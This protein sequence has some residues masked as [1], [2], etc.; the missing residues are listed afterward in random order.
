MINDHVYWNKSA[1]ELEE[2]VRVAAARQDLPVQRTSTPRPQWR[3]DPYRGQP[4]YHVIRRFVEAWKADNEADMA[5]KH[6]NVGDPFLK[7]LEE[8]GLRGMGGAG[9]PT[10][11]KWSAVR[12]APGKEKYVVCNG[13]ESEPGTFKD[14][15]LLVFTPHLM[16]EG[17]ILAGL[18][19]G[20]TRGYI[21]IRHEYQEQIKA[22]EAEIARAQANHFCGSNIL[23][24]DFS[25]PVEVFVSPGGYICGEETALLEAMEDRRAEP[26]NKPPI[27]VFEG[28]YGKPTIINNV[29]TFSWVPSIVL[30]GGPWYRELG[31]HQARGMR[32][33][34]ISGHVARPGVYEVPLG[35]TVG[36][37][38]FGTA[39]G[40]SG[41]RRL[42]AVAT[43]GPSSG[44]LP[45][46]LDLTKAPPRFVQTLCDR[47]VVAPGATQ[48]DI[49]DMPLD[50]DVLQPFPDFMLGAA[51]V[52]YG[53]DADMLEA[54]LNC[55][56]FFRNESC[57]KCVP[58]RVGT[59]KMVEMIRALLAGQRHDDL[60]T[61]DELAQTM[62]LSAICGL[63]QVA[64]N[65][66]VTVLRY[67][68]EDLYKHQK[69]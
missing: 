66:L 65:P 3:I 1:R 47:K 27:M 32:F 63:G 56:T 14:R 7:K 9:F 29:E 5:K 34:S 46:V 48:L 51:F 50:F 26:R 54:A 49:L 40:M 39:G 18:V 61:L 24:S 11:R 52:V 25:F 38:I 8:A 21:Y 22:V 16:V 43:S 19:S 33:V 23:G 68:R 57:G 60:S 10:Y 69:A 55:V 28:L 20:A 30:A 62:L 36:E 4:C 64:A 13:D 42:K 44:F 41:G 53:H 67:F 2:L 35:Q 12:G 45:A 6:M 31:T 37:L 58:C 59:H 17:V 15:D